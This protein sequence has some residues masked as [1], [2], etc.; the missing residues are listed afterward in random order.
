MRQSLA[1]FELQVHFAHAVQ[2][3]LAVS[4]EESLRRFTTFYKVAVDNDAG[5]PAD[6]WRFDPDQPRWQEL[7]AAVDGGAD[8][9]RY[10]WE[11]SDWEFERHCFGY[12]YWADQR[13]VRIHFGNSPDGLA[14]RP[15]SAASR[16][17]ELRGIVREVLERHPEATFVRGT[18]WL[19]H[20]PAYPRLFPPAYID[21]LVPIGYLYPFTALWGQ[22][23]DRFGEVKPALAEAFHRA[24]AHATTLDRLNSAFPLQ[25]LATTGS[26][27]DFRRHYV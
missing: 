8:P 20:V 15:D 9:A 23:L 27:A 4:A 3:V 26:L 7:V 2:R 18:S 17:A 19:Y 14:L 12:D 13:A 1:Y 6:R 10:V 25:V 22:F 5:S 24:M 21:S 11:R 16:T